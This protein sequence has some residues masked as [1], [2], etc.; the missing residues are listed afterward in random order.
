MPILHFKGKS[1]IQNH[2]HTVK[3][4]ELDP[5]KVKGTSK[6]PSLDDNLIIHGDNLK[7]LKALLPTH[8]GKVKCIFIDPP[9]NTGNEHWVYNDNVNS[10]MIK[11]WLG[12]EV[13][14]DDL[15]R[16]DKWCC[17]M[18]PRLMLLNELLR[19]DGA[20]FISIDDNEHE[21]LQM[22]MNEIFGEE[23]FIANVVWQKKYSPQNDAK[24]FS[25]MHDYI[26]V[27]AKNKEVW[28]PIALDRTEEQDSAYKNPDND[29]R[30]P[31]KATDSTCNKSRSQRPNLYYPITNSHT[32][33]EILPLETRVWRFSR[34][35]HEQKARDN[36]V[37][38]GANGK[39]KVPAYKSFLSEVKQGRVP[40]TIWSY[41]EAGHNQLARQELNEILPDAP[42]DTPKP[43]QLIERIIQIACAP[44]EEEIILDSFAGSG[45]TAHAVLK[46]NNEDNGNRK[47]ITIECEDYA[48]KITAERVRRVIKGVKESKNEN[49]QKGLGGSFSYYELGDPLDI[50][51]M[52]D[53]KKLPTFE[54]LAHYAF[55]TSTGETFDPKKMSEKDCYLGAS[56]TYEVFMLYAP[57]GDKLREMALNLDFAEKIEKKFPKK[58]KLVFAPACYLEEYDLRDRNIRFAQLPF[59]IYRLA[60]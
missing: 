35:V 59:E 28:R 38:W 3:F 60:E 46:L 11:E 31:W 22:M 34:D 36:R 37:W 10:P 45:T 58:P 56:S 27:F 18:Y 8:A 40:T 25:D 6:T 47:F 26:V 24:W 4:H 12:K 1:A 9:Y 50:D 48:D 14:R 30:G 5:V 41:E 16:H 32:G 17:M 15:T 13:V 57:D 44:S 52:L 7:A 51:S 23:N 33:K 39:N 2:H 29:P 53:G 54:N 21:Q 42:F 20:I 55:F 43:V 19:E 49:L